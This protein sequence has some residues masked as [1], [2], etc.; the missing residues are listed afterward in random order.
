MRESVGM[1]TRDHTYAQYLRDNDV[2]LLKQI[3]KK[4]KDVEKKLHGSPPS[5]LSSGKTP[6]PTFKDEDEHNVGR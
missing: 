2:I 6:F 1:Q 3:H 5:D 4:W